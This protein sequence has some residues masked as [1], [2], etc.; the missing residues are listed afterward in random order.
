[1]VGENILGHA[2]LMD[3]EIL[4]S[5]YRLGRYRYGIITMRRKRGEENGA[6]TSMVDDIDQWPNILFDSG[7]LSYL[8]SCGIFA[9]F[10]MKS[11][12]ARIFLLTESLS[13]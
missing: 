12:D 7:H 1:M 10:F 13:Y 11:H 5:I 4:S 6:I 9:E 2:L 3:G 8:R